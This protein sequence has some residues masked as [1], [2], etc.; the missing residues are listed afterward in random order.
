MPCQLR[1]KPS[2]LYRPPVSSKVNV[3]EIFLG[4]PEFSQDG[5]ILSGTSAVKVSATTSSTGFT[6]HGYLLWT[7]NQISPGTRPFRKRFG[8]IG[9]NGSSALRAKP[10]M[11][12]PEG[13]G[14]NNDTLPQAFG[15]GK[16]FCGACC[17]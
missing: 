11:V 1:V 7:R 2:P 12:I 4:S 9:M 5:P 17:G 10:R 16:V 13:A 3:A 8:N 14:S 15:D 6:K